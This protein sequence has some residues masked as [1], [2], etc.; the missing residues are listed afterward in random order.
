MG[1]IG[2]GLVKNQKKTRENKGF[3]TPDKVLDIK[4]V[5][6]E[7]WHNF[8]TEEIHKVNILPW[9]I[10]SKKDFACLQKGDFKKNV[11]DWAYSLNYWCHPRVHGE[12]D[13]ICLKKNFGKRCV[14]CEEA[15]KKWEIYN[16][17]Q[18]TENKDAAGSLTSKLRSM[19]NQ[20]V[21]T[22]ELRGKNSFFESSDY[23][24]ENPLIDKATECE[25]GEE[26]VSF[27]ETDMEEGKI[28]KFKRPKKAMDPY[29][30][31]EFRDRKKP[32]SKKLLEGVVSFGE[33]IH[34][35]TPEEV[36]EFFYGASFV[37]DSES[38]EDP[39]EEE[40][41]LDEDIES[42]EEEEEELEDDDSEDDSEEDD[43]E[44]EEEEEEEPPKKSK[45]KK[46]KSDDSDKK[47]KQKC[48]AGGKFGADYGTFEACDD[49]SKDMDC[50]KAH[51]KL[52]K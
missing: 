10:K 24:F 33:L 41:E 35:P 20:E 25:D 26:P 1:K 47:K 22:P 45:K 44:E 9:K 39:D 21:L 12:K 17:N 19:Y 48:P 4:A 27:Y 52:N 32:I 37:P 18:T 36:S 14:I 2:K 51:K 11:G 28:V 8:K 46:E 29:T 31:F 38:E 43:S 34:I 49:C 40:E 6:G 5:T 16:K 30:S 7:D 3:V 42:D 50:Y 15:D 23:I 13:V